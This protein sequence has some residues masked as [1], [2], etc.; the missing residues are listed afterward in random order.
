[1]LHVPPR[2]DAADPSASA[3]RQVPMLH[4]PPRPDAADPSADASRQVPM[5]HAPPR[6]DAADPSADASR[7]VPMLH[8]PPRLGASR[9]GWLGRGVWLSS[10]ETRQ[11]RSA[12]RA[13]SIL[14]NGVIDGT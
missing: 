2:P 6:P 14:L 7:Q 13:C 5:L 9:Q 1:M 3:P 12:D 11:A 4:A 10:G 8:A